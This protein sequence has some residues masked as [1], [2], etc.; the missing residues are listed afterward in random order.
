MQCTSFADLGELLRLPSCLIYS[1][2]MGCL[3]SHSELP[4][5]KEPDAFLTVMRLS[6]LF[7][8]CI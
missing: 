1:R 6:I 5:Q 4:T 2:S 3:V 8:L 7:L